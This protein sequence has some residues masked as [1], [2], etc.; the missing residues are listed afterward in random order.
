[1]Q[2]TTSNATQLT[3]QTVENEER[4]AEIAALVAEIAVLETAAAER[5]RL[6]EA[7]KARLF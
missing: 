2:I 7:E 5:E 6:A 3:I 4:A 1:M